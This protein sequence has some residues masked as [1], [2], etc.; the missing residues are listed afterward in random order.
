MADTFDVS[1]GA[2]YAVLFSVLGVFTILAVLSTGIGASFLPVSIQ[3][4]IVAH[5]G[6]DGNLTVSG[7]MDTSSKSEETSNHKTGLLA[8]DFFL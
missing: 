1:E 5:G 6:K 7:K 3:N 4:L 8:T 2:A